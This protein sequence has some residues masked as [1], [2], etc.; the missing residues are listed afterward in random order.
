[1]ASWRK[2]GLSLPKAA[3]ST[4]SVLMVAKRFTPTHI[5]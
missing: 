2:D 5:S 3:R 4:D 1:M